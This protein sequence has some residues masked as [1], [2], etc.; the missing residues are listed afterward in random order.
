VPSPPT[1][2]DVLRVWERGE[3][4]HPVDRALSLLGLVTDMPRDAL[5]RL[6]IGRRDAM[7]FAARAAVFGGSLQGFARCEHCA[8]PVEVSLTPP[9]FDT[10]SPAA[11]LEEGWRPLA[12]DGRSGEYRLP[13]SYDLAAI[14]GCDSVEQ[15]RRDL[16]ERCVRDADAQAEAVAIGRISAQMEASSLDLDLTC[17]DCGHTWRLDFDIGVYF[18]GE[19]KSRALRLL[20][21]V[22]ALAGRFGWHERDILQMSDRRRALY[23]ELA[24]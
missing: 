1:A 18:W 2:E 10:G 12:S 8:A 16:V 21:E 15:A 22:A 13:T 24:S 19:L 7:L 14:A 6:D 11:T 3:T 20:R 5:A 23:L 9:P 4:E 17:P